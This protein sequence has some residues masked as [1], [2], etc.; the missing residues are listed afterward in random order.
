MFNN[1]HGAK[2]VH[3]SPMKRKS[4]LDLVN[5]EDDLHDMVLKGSSQVNNCGTMTPKQSLISRLHLEP[6]K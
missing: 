5:F 1:G 6:Q 3:N 4:K 2:S